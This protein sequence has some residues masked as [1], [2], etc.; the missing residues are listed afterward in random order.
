[1][2]ENVKPDPV[3]PLTVKARPAKIE[4]SEIE[5]RDKKAWVFS[6]A[7]CV[8]RR[9]SAL[10]VISPQSALRLRRGTQRR[11][12]GCGSA[13]LRPVPPVAEHAGTL[14]P[15]VVQAAARAKFLS[16]IS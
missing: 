14:I 6:A 16:F 1:V 4:A 15:Q 8:S 7:L 10:T 11:K 3:G 13:A 9:S 12:F 2:R 5:T